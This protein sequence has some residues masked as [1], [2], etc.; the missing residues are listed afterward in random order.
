MNRRTYAWPERTVLIHFSGSNSFIYVFS[1]IFVNIIRFLS[2]SR[3]KHEFTTANI[4][5]NRRMHI[6]NSRTIAKHMKHPKRDDMVVIATC[7]QS[8]LPFGITVRR[9]GKE[10][11]FNWAFKISESSAKREGFDRNKVSGNIYNA[12]TYPGCPHCGATT[13][14]Q[15]G[16]CKRFVCMRPEQKIVRC[17]VCGN[18]GE[19]SVADSF[20]LSGGDM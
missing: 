15:C 3:Q 11:E 12:S 5:D 18:E 17:P 8:R 2:G 19:V 13:W 6:L 1:F 9:V 16:K 7:Q 20:D 14:F 10:Y 4:S